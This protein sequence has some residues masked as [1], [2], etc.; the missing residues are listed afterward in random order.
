MPDASLPVL[1]RGN[2]V[3]VFLHG[4][5]LPGM[6][7]AYARQ[8]KAAG[9]RSVL[10]RLH[11]P[12][13]DWLE[14]SAMYAATQAHQ[15]RTTALVEGLA[16]SSASFLLQAFSERRI[17]K[18]A[19]LMVHA[20]HMTASGRAEDHEAAAQ[21]LKTVRTR[22]ASAYARSGQPVAVIDGCTRTTAAAWP[23]R[24]PSSKSRWR[25]CG[26]RSMSGT[27]GCARPCRA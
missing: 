5:I 19:L 8:L 25:G 27:T 7:E 9:S 12:G 6:A 1:D 24:M 13:G 15:G 16:A 10:V 17:A 11:S 23:I 18:N 4:D 22:L 21:V 26:R 14:S 2:Q 3:E 20:P